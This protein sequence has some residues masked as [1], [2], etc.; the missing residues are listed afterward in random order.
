MLLAVGL[1]RWPLITARS[2]RLLFLGAVGI[3]T[4]AN[5]GYR[6]GP[7]DP[8]GNGSGIFFPRL[9]VISFALVLAS[10]LMRDERTI[11]GRILSARVLVA[12]GTI[13]Y[14]I[15]LWHFLIIKRLSTTPVWWS[16]GTNLILVLGLTFAVATTSWIVLERPL[17]RAKDDLASLRRRRETDTGSGHGA[18]ARLAGLGLAP[19]VAPER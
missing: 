12:A 5:F 16:E 14:G 7:P 19:S 17:M 11:L 1:E 18:A 15:Y 6:I 4:L 9:M 10:V 3:A 8:Y 13:S 2:S